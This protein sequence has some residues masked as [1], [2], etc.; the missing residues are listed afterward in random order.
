MRSR[1]TEILICSDQKK[2]GNGFFWPSIPRSDFNTFLFTSLSFPN[3]CFSLFPRSLGCRIPDCIRVTDSTTQSVRSQV[4]VPSPTDHGTLISDFLRQSY[5]LFGY[6]LPLLCVTSTH[7]F[8]ISHSRS[9]DSDPLRAKASKICVLVLG[10][11]YGA[12]IYVHES[13]IVRNA[14]SACS[15]LF[16]RRFGFRSH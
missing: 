12:F 10:N 8:S 1:R 13:I 11:I 5:G 16:A 6:S 7:S 9:F 15:S 14:I 2:P 3:Y 4:K